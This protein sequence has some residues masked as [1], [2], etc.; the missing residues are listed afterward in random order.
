MSHVAQLSAD[1]RF[2]KLFVAR[3]IS[4][5]G[6]GIAP[7]ALAFGVLALPNTDATSLSLVLAAQAVPLVLMLPVGGVVAD[8][9]GRAR[10]IAYTDLVL[11]AVI[12]VMSFLFINGSVTIPALV[13]LSFIIGCLNGLWWP[14]YSGLTPDVVTDEL[15]Q[16]ANA[17]L[18]MASNVGLIAGSA[19]GGLLV[20]AVGAGIAIAVDSATFLI[21]GL[22][23]FTFRH[24]SKPHDSGQGMFGDLAHGWRLFLSFRW[25]VIVVL[26]FSTIVMAL[27]GAEHVMG[28]VLAIDEY[29]GAAG[30][31]VVLAFQSAGLLAGGFASSRVNIRR[32]MLFGM[33]I[34]LTLPLWLISLAF[35]APLWIISLGSFAWGVSIEF[36]QVLWYTA[37][38][39]NVPREALSRV[40]SYEAMGSLMFGPIGLALAG[41][42]VA[43]VGLQASFLICAAVVTIAILLTLLSRSVRT[44]TSS[45]AES[46]A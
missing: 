1:R 22:M 34:T 18:S 31:A 33:L 40:S 15:L 45:I 6:N 4:N 8:R 38:Q 7:I 43:V 9:L 28:P 26:S 27:Y 37:L 32:P 14:A 13:L 41:P 36:F 5:L 29:G 44:L 35:A 11:S 42:L 17:Y 16:P 10:V 25:V 30:W 3:T 23:V 12:A 24:V 20:A 21:A 2:R 46:A 19:I 39:T